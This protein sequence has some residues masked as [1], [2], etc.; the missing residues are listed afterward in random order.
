MFIENLASGFKSSFV[1]KFTHLFPSSC[2]LSKQGPELYIIY[3][4]GKRDLGYA[5]KYV[6]IVYYTDGKTSER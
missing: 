2:Y 3:K 6:N 5:I 4:K 1:L